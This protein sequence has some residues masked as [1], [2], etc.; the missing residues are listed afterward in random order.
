[1]APERFGGVSDAR[2]DVYSLG[3]TLYELLTL[4]PAFAETDRGRLIKRITHDEPPPPRKLDPRVPRDLETIVLK[5]TVK[6][7]RL[8]YQSAEE[9]CED[10]RRF[11]ADRPIRARRSALWEHAWRWCR[12]NPALAVLGALAAAALLTALGLG[13]GLAAYQYRAARDLRAAL[14]ES[15]RLAADLALDR[16]LERC[17]RG[18]CGEG[19]LWLAHSLQMAPTQ[20]D[21]LEHAIRLNLGAWRRSLHVLQRVWEH[22]EA[23]S[24]VAVAANSKTIV[25]GSRDGKVR[26]WDA[27]TGQPKGA[28]LP[29][30]C[31]ITRATFSQ[32][33]RT[34]LTCDKAHKAYL[35][36][37][38]TGQLLGKAVSYPGS[39]L[40]VHFAGC[41][42]PGAP[43]SVS[44]AA[45][46]P[47][48]AILKGK[49][50]V[51]LFARAA[52][53]KASGL[54]HDFMVRVG[55]FTPDGKRLVTGGG[56][57]DQGRVRLWDLATGRVLHTFAHE[58]PVEA[59][60][61][62]RDGTRLLTGTRF[63]KARLWNLATCTQIGMSLQHAAPVRALAFSSDGEYFLTGSADGKARVWQTAT[64]T[65]VG[66][67]LEHQGPITALVF[68]AGDRYV[69]TA[70]A[71]RT[72]RL[73]QLAPAQPAGVALPCSSYFNA[74]AFDPAGKILA[75]AGDDKTV[76]LWDTA[77]GKSWGPGRLDHPDEVHAVAFT[78]DGGVLVSGCDDG[79]A[80]LWE[81]ATG[82]PRGPALQQHS[83]VRCVAVNEAGTAIVTA[84]A[85]GVG[86]LRN[87]M[88]GEAL[89]EFPHKSAVGAVAVSPDGR[90]VLTGAQN[91]TARLWTVNGEPLAEPLLHRSFVRAVA[92][93]RDSTM[94]LTGSADTTARLW[95]VR[96]GRARGNPLRHQSEVRVVAF[97]PDGKLLAT[98]DWEHIV[99]LWDEATRKP[100]GPPLLH[101][102]A[103]LALTFPG[104]G[105]S[106]VSASTEENRVRRWPVPTPFLGDRSRIVLWMQVATG[107][108]L[109]PAGGVLVLDAAAWQERRRRLDDL[110]GPALP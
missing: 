33:G 85:G 61:L 82:K 4:R 65:L 107:L 110:G 69:L 108:E 74:M 57:G 80:R 25:T 27:D 77:T 109:D 41:P 49:R 29:H 94:A 83:R 104:D 106:L 18:D 105:V 86:V 100:V 17:A 66:Q 44:V 20:A 79:S 87:S 8:R 37:A 58:G 71:D 36:N 59:L 11:L 43:G 42:S 88:S 81:V 103:I 45:A 75:T 39:I 3:L 67:P 38:A 9:M 22:P 90:L 15:Q 48:V 14:L 76:R 54:R 1:M 73:W 93:S 50:T 62:S 53:S 47:Y 64:M 28:P 7:P 26:L 10:L 6:E 91:G 19:M 23:V 101:R 40:A 98:G 96:T 99:R 51:R 97:S 2:G 102:G 12:R 31:A 16:G 78:G 89:A 52:E 35:W 55:V 34:L 70:S 46:T 95:D 21:Q 84:G 24:A 68:N 63:W 13:V 56:E 5:A 30:P 32:D 60:A 72:A 92:F